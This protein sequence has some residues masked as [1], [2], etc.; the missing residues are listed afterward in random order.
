MQGATLEFEQVYVAFHE[1]IL[2][3]LLRMVGE[4]EAEDL[5]QDV[6]IKI[7][8]SLADFRGVS[9]LSTWV[10]RIATNAA[11]DRLRSAAFVQEDG[12]TP[13]DEETCEPG[14]LA[15]QPLLPDEQVSLKEM[16]DC[17]GSYLQDLPAAYRTVFILSDLE[18][19]PNR[20]IAEIL[21]IS[22]DTVKIRLHRGRAMLLQRLKDNC[23][24]EDW[25]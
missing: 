1:R 16:Y 12:T 19:L 21:G 4:G 3:Y 9:Q 13:L 2:R 25:L 18:E 5:A 22:L 14:C 23:K 7:N 6:F 11:I 15:E 10:Y 24:A 20:E 8:R 17:F